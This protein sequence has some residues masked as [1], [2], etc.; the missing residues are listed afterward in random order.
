MSFGA[1]SITS[2]GWWQVLT[3]WLHS[4]L[5]DVY[6]GVKPTHFYLKD[7]YKSLIQL[8]EMVSPLS[9]LI[10]HHMYPNSKESPTIP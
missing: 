3:R 7:N 5:E 8:D 6:S 1:E 10:T 4:P 2:T 9:S